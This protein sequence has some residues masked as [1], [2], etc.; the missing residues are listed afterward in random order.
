MDQLQTMMKDKEVHTSLIFET[1]PTMPLELRAGIEI[2][3]Y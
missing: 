3:T 1:I 2:L